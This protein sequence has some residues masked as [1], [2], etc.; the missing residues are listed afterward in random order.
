MENLSFDRWF[1]NIGGFR[2][3]TI[4][5]REREGVRVNIEFKDLVSA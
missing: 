3:L 2:M 4:F 5:Q 1:L